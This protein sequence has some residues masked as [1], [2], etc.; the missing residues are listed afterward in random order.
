[1]V[2]STDP[3]PPWWQTPPLSTAEALFRRHLSQQPNKRQDR[4]R[5][6]L[7]VCFLGTTD[8]TRNKETS[9][10]F[11]FS[12][13]GKKQKN[14][15]FF[16]FFV[17]GQKMK[18]Q[19][20]SS[21]SWT[22]KQV[23]ISFLR[24]WAKNKKQKNGLY[25][26]FFVFGKKANKQNFSSIPCFLCYNQKQTYHSMFHFI[27]GWALWLPSVLPFTVLFKIKVL[28]FDTVTSTPPK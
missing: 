6:L 22:Q 12:F 4:R 28:P 5:Y 9:L 21:I 20:F 11:V 2:A 13:L 8:T 25:F 27:G 24:F 1:M 16:R 15:L 14:G 23:F 19:K 26:H 7:T 17:F 10:Y 18:K 3:L